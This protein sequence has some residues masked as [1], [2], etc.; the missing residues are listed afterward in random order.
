MKYEYPALTTTEED[1]LVAQNRKCGWGF[2]HELLVELVRKFVDGDILDKAKVDF[3][4]EDGN[5][6]ELANLLLEN[7]IDEAY[8]WI[9][10]VVPAVVE[11]EG[12]CK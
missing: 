2:T 3:R 12:D 11:K 5:V 1:I 8:E 6:H 10:R 9:D 4:L 7:K